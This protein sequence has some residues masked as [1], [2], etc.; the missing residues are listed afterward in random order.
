MEIKVAS[1]KTLKRQEPIGQIIGVVMMTRSKPY[2]D[3]LIEALKSPQEAQ[4]YLLDINLIN[5]SL[6]PW[7]A[8]GCAAVVP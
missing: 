2:Q 1:V 4:A 6:F 3:E 5:K 7:F 8:P